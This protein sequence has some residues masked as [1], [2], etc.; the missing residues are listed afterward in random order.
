MLACCRYLNSTTSQLGMMASQ[1]TGCVLVAA[2]WQAQVRNLL[3]RTLG[4]FRHA[5]IADSLQRKAVE[6]DQSSA[7][8]SNQRDQLNQKL[9]RFR[10]IEKRE[11]WVMEREAALNSAVLSGL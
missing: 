5:C 8:W 6:F 1:D 11:K 7:Q 9:D 4:A 3:Q 2:I 10:N